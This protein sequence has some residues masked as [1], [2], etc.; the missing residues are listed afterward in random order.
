MIKF[1]T[2]LTGILF[3]VIPEG[4]ATRYEDFVLAENCIWALFESGTI[5]LFDTRTGERTRKKVP[6][7]VPVKILTTDNTGVPVIMDDSGRIRRYNAPD[8]TWSDVA[9]CNPGIYSIVFDSKGNAYTI[10]SEG[11]TDLA[12][13]QTYY[14]NN[15]L[16]HQVQF[17]DAWRKPACWFMDRTNHIWIG[18]GFGEWGGELIVFDTDRK[19]FM[20]PEFDNSFRITLWPVQSFFEDDRAVY[21]SAGMMHF[22]TKGGIVKFESFR[23]KPLF[24]S[25][26]HWNNNVQSDSMTEGEYIGPAAYNPYSRSLYFYSHNGFFRGDVSGDLS[27]ARNWEKIVQPQL[28]WTSGQPDAVGSPMNVTKLSV[29]DK[30]RFVFLSTNDGIGLFDGKK[31]IMIR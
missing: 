31:V 12:T 21:L 9:M 29:I 3:L 26:T 1:F 15:S 16:N 8:N 22:S 20:S 18:W 5:E 7:D 4:K 6:A 25:E 24:I 28:Q 14:I 13:K 17:R 11:I 10:A 2:L 23:G 30:D 27:D 19:K